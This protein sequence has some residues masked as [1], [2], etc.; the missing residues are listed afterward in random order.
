MAERPRSDPLFNKDTPYQ[1]IWQWFKARHIGNNS[2]HEL[3]RIHLKWKKIAAE[4][5]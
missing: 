2:E 5:K 4:V 3:R 1:D